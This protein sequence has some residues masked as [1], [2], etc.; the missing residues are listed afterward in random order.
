LTAA[1]GTQ[2]E[3]RRL[4]PT[5]PFDATMC[6]LWSLLDFLERISYNPAKV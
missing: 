3:G 1:V 6:G 4:S 5:F 2:E